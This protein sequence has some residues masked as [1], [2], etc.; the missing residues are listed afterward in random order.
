M[1]PKA[2]WIAAGL[3]LVLVVAAGLAFFL[4]SLDH[5]VKAA[6]EHYGPRIAG[7]PVTVDSVAISARDGR[8]VVRGLSVGVPQGYASPRTLGVEEIV[9]ALDPATLAKDVV[10][11]RDILVQSPQVAY[12]LRGGT[13]NLETIQRSIDAAT[14][15][16]PG[17][18]GEGTGEATGTKRRYR[19]DRI[20]LRGARVTLRGPVK[21]EIA[22]DLPDVEVRDLGSDGRGVTAAEAARA[23]NGA[24]TARIAQKVLTNA[25]LLRRGGLQGA[26]DALR[27]LINR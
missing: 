7:V 27:G 8:G 25:D 6:I 4:T 2:R 5:V 1:S 15:K 14:R 9:V 10:V 13:N 12:E 3:A 20:T 23:V 26:R 22:F 16:A 11:I 19:I 21:G 17:A 24:L 18:A